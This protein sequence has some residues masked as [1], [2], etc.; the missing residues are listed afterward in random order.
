MVWPS[1]HARHPIERN[2]PAGGGGPYRFSRN[3]DYVGQALLTPGLALLVGA[4]WTLLALVPALLI[5]RCGVIGREERYLE[6]RFGEE[7]RH[8]RQQVRRWL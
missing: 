2:P 8:Y 3:P 1:R 7:Y 6:H 4:P 5:V